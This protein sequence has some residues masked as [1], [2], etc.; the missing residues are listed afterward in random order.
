[1]ISDNISPSTIKFPRKEKKERER[2]T[3]YSKRLLTSLI[4]MILIY[5]YICIKRA[6][7]TSYYLTI[8]S[9]DLINYSWIHLKKN[10]N[11]YNI[12]WNYSHRIKS[13]RKKSLNLR[14]KKRKREICHWHISLDLDP[15]DL[16]RFAEKRKN[17][18]VQES[19]VV[20]KRRRRRGKNQKKKKRN[21]T[22]I[23]VARRYH[24]RNFQRSPHGWLISLPA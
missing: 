20:S 19:H 23:S 6:I 2:K 3:Y 16:E 15:Y 8:F 17:L 10:F 7:K 4:S 12:H 1:M 22:R 24:R 21:F 14:K 11:Y 5:I 9:S 13:K 18:T